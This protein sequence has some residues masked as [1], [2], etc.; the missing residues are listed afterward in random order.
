MTRECPQGSSFGSLMWN[1]FQNDLALHINSGKLNMYADDHH[2]TGKLNIYDDEHE[3]YSTG[4]DL[5]KV[6][7]TI[8]E[9]GELA[10]TWYKNYLLANV[11]KFQTTV[12][13]PRRLNVTNTHKCGALKFMTKH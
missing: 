1:I 6:R 13:N 10:A 12:I 4:Y 9:A 5:E 2:S 3:I 8:V 11:D 7:A